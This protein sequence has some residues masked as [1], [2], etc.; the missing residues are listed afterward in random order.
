MRKRI[1]IALTLGSAFFLPAGL[2]AIETDSASAFE[3]QLSQAK[4]SMMSDP[5]AALRHAQSAASTAE[6]M[7][8]EE[9]ALAKATSQWL[10]GEALTR[11]N[12]AKQAEPVIQEALRT[13][14]EEDPNSKLHADLLKSRAAI[15]GQI[16]KPENALKILHN[17]FKIYEQLGETRS[18]AI[19]LHNIASVYYEARDYA[20]VLKYYNQA[21]S[22]YPDDAVLSLSAHNNLGNTYRD[23]GDFAEA[24]AEYEK[25]LNIARDMES[26]LLQARILNNL[27]YSQF[28]QED[29]SAAD[30]TALKGLKIAGS[31]AADWKPFLWGTRAKIAFA[32]NRLGQAERYINLAL[33]NV[34][35]K[36]SQMEF[37]D[38]HKAAYQIYKKLG[39]P[40]VALTHLE[41]FK[42]LDDNGRNLAAS[43]NSALMAAQFDEANRELRISKLEAKQTQREMALAESQT[44]LRLAIV[45]LIATLLVIGGMF[46]AITS[47]RRQRQKVTEANAQLSHAAKH[48]MLTGLANRAYYRD[49]LTAALK[50]TVGSD[51]R[52]AVM[53]ID[54]DRFKAVN[55]THG[56]EI[57]DKLLCEVAEQLTGIGGEKASAV[58]LGAMSLHWLSPTWTCLLIRWL[59]VKRS[60]K[61]W[62]QTMLL[63]G[64]P[65]ISV[66]LSVW[67]LAPMTVILLPC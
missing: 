33:N 10:E 26:E 18:Q 55:D 4:S 13:V 27:A 34:D 62:Q 14:S 44:K 56:H 15:I 43:T 58:R 9:A 50:N 53:L 59:W 47:I 17:A 66:P 49:L 63:A 11:L 54:L 22:I 64:C 48:D 38:H 52:C 25:A 51:R 21:E 46:F 7:P 16:G 60:S 29:Y 28:A 3:N 24:E 19:I 31:A 61:S 42:R 45:S 37:R 23:M 57:G 8:A 39:K 30:K 1:L 35:P 5:G 20:R 32:Q 40:Q 67:R 41:A 36:N 2:Q 65:L 6:S 12:K